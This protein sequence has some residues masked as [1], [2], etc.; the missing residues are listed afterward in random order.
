VEAQKI[1]AQTIR[2]RIAQLEK[3]IAALQARIHEIAKEKATYD[4]LKQD[5]QIAR[6]NYGRAHQQLEQSRMAHSLQQDRQML[7][8]IDRPITPVQPFKPNRLFIALGGLFA[9]LLLAMAAAVTVDHFDHRF[10]TVYQIER[11]LNVPV[12]GSVPSLT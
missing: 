1:T 3:I 10:K 6:E 2:A 4:S 12:F 8:L 9:G 7:T 11:N 5:F